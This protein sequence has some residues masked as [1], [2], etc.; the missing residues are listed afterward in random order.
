MRVDSTNLDHI[1]IEPRLLRKSSRIKQTI[2]PM[3][4]DENGYLSS[5]RTDSVNDLSSTIINPVTPVKQILST[6]KSEGIDGL[7]L[8]YKSKDLKATLIDKDFS[9]ESAI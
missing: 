8:R 6:D 4:N 5:D 2:Q 1:D 3:V 7:Y 9:I